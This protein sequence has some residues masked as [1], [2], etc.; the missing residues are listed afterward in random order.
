MFLFLE[1]K[2]EEHRAPRDFAEMKKFAGELA[3][4]GTLRRG[5][6][7][8]PESIAA[9]VRVRDGKAYVRDGPFAESKEVVAGFWIVDVA[10]HAEAI[11]IARQCPHARHG[12]VEVHRAQWRDTVPDPERGN[13]FLFAFCM[14]P[15][16]TDPDGAK[17]REMIAFM[18]GLKREGKFIE[19]APLAL[20]PP[21]ARIETRGGKTL[22]IDGPF[23]ESKEGV[24]GYC[25]VRV[26]GRAE[27]IDLASRVPHA[28]WGTTEVREIIFFDR[29]RPPAPAPS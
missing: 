14:E 26:A 13:P 19:T 25:L 15:G 12:I 23:A 24:G 7:L 17:M 1:R 8:E 3:A 20:D 18:E 2:G 6:P 10:G 16:L 5:A 4:R 28:R 27:A 9:R 29:T 21:P 11:E 22:V